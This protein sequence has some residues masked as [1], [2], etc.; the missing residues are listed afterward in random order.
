MLSGLV[1]ESS[2]LILIGFN[3][4]EV[5]AQ[6]YTEILCTLARDVGQAGVQLDIFTTG[7]RRHMWK[8]GVI[9]QSYS[10]SE[11]FVN[12]ISPLIVDRLGGW[13]FEMKF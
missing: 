4:C 11:A 12:T 7:G 5:T 3:P 1:P 13:F 9:V 6:S 10:D 2:F 8:S